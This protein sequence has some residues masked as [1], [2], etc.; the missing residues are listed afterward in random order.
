MDEFTYHSLA[1]P[2]IFQL[3]YKEALVKP[4]FLISDFAKFDRPLQL[5][6]AFQALQQFVEK[7]Q[8]YPKPRNEQDAV[9]VLELTKALVGTV[10]DKPELDE[11]LIKEL[12]YQSAG[13]LSPMVAVYGG[14]AAQEVLKVSTL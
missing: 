13:E 2:M 8:R 12:A 4:E 9:Q 14:L 6:L 10:E 3:S 5:H 7:N 1:H 11:K